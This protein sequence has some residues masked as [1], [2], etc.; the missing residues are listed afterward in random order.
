MMSSTMF[1]IQ[2][3]PKIL[4]THDYAEVDQYDVA[5]LFTIVKNIL[6]LANDVVQSFVSVYICHSNILYLTIFFS[7]HW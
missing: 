7:F 5:P 6:N 4:A 2:I 3:K 1:D